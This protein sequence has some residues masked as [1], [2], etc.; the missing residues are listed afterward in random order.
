MKSSIKA[1]GLAI[2]L[3]GGA[4][5][6]APAFAEYTAAIPGVPGFIGERASDDA[7]VTKVVTIKPTTKWVN[8]NQDEVVKFV[9]EASGKSFVWNFDTKD[10]ASFDLAAAAPEVLG[11]HHVQVYVD[12]MTGTGD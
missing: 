9:D 5:A 2:A 3:A 1:L 6:G 7:G 12:S 8:V 10:W 11:N 4:I